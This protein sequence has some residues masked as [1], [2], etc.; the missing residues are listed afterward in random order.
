MSITRKDYEFLNR[1]YEELEEAEVLNAEDVEKFEDLLY[2]LEK[3]G[4]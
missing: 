3:E 2:R 1:L 4:A